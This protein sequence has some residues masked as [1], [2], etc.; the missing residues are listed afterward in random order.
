MGMHYYAEGLEYLVL[1]RTYEYR[2]HESPGNQIS[3]QYRH[4]EACMGSVT[5]SVVDVP[6]YLRRY[7]S[8]FE[9]QK[10]SFIS[11]FRS[12]SMLLDPDPGQPNE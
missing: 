5:G 2:K 3:S 1:Y 10:T 8:F 4:R 9:R 12:I 7:K 11:K 6:L